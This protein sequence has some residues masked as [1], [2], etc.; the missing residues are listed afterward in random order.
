MLRSYPKNVTAQHSTHQTVGKA[1][2]ECSIEASLASKEHRRETMASSR[3][4]NNPSTPPIISTM[5]KRS[6]LFSSIIAAA[7]GDASASYKRNWI[8]LDKNLQFQPSDETVNDPKL[9]TVQTQHLRQLWGRQNSLQ[10]PAES[11]FVDGSETYY[12]EYAQA[13]RF[14]GFYQD[15]AACA[16]DTVDCVGN[17]VCQRFALWAAVR[18]STADIR[19]CVVV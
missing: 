13:W 15:C 3:K 9:Q 1:L 14:L 10:A 19:R 12:D 2:V 16:D 11:I 6:T 4:L 5:M 7:A 17:I 18:L 8:S